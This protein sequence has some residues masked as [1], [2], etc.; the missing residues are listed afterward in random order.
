MQRTPSASSNEPDMVTPGVHQRPLA[1]LPKSLSTPA[2]APRP[3]RASALRAGDSEAIDASRPIVNRRQSAGTSERSAGFEDTPGH[4]R[5]SL[6]VTVA[7]TQTPNVAPRTN[8]AAALRAAAGPDGMAPLLEDAEDATSGTKRAGAYI[9]PATVRRESFGT[10]GRSDSSAFSNTPG[11][12]R[13][14]LNVSVASVRQPTIAPRPTKASTL[15][16]GTPIAESIVRPAVPTVAAIDARTDH[17]DQ[18]RFDRRL[19]SSKS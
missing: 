2:I 14:S 17:T 12:R 1:V 8:R 9:R 18:G 13:H 16:A 11:F 7:S 10:S 19:T 3:T 15:R 4:R 5:R 6:Q